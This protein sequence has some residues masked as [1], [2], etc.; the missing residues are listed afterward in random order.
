MFDKGQCT[1]CFFCLYPTT[2]KKELQMSPTR[3]LCTFICASL[4]LFT[5][6]AA[7]SAT[8]GYDSFSYAADSLSGKNG[9]TG[10]SG[11]WG[12][13]K[14]NIVATG[15]TYGGLPVLAGTTQL[16]LTSNLQT[17]TSTRALTTT[18]G[19]V[20]TTI[21]YSFLLKPDKTTIFDYCGLNIGAGGTQVFIG[22]QGTN[23]VLNKAG[24][25]GTNVSI[26]FD[27]VGFT[28]G[29][30]AFLV[31]KMVFTSGIDS[32]TIYI[33]PTAGLSAPDVPSSHVGSKKDLD[34]GTFSSLVISGGRGFSANNSQLDEIRIATTYSDVVLPIQL[35]SFTAHTPSGLQ[36]VDFGWTTLTETNNYGFIVQ[37]SVIA[38]SLFE[39]IPNS[40]V[41]GH[42]TTT[43]PQ[44][45]SW[46]QHNVN[47]G[48]WYYRLKQIDLD[49]SIH[50]TD[51]VEVVVAALTGTQ[52]QNVPLVFSLSQNYPNPF[53]PTTL[54]RYT[55]AKQGP[56]S[57]KVYNALGQEVA[58]LVEG[59]QQAGEYQMRLDAGTLASGTYFYRLNTDEFTSSKKL[60]V[61]R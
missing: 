45:Y 4:S 1:Q 61:L 50:Y 52:E 43:V 53:N 58:V 17:T 20:G 21:W 13:G 59:V 22:Y 31:L 16:N 48:T 32:A 12:A 5:F 44:S 10:W 49:G 56:V 55:L 37:G 39:D 26:S 7:K 23:F 42:G 24:G 8:D 60:I 6:Q 11:A 47:H 38:S 34:V 2:Q 29:Q 15:L 27:S 40:F 35:S 51:A 9:G 18:M 41:P 30:T 54:I 57:L 19:T 3:L 28:V 36:Q 46:T 33:N 14:I 25:G